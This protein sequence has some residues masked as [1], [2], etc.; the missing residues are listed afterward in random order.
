MTMRTISVLA[1]LAL[2]AS[3][4]LYSQVR[5]TDLKEMIGSS[6]MIFSGVVTE[7]EGGEDENGD[8]VTWTT[9]RVESPIRGVL[10]GSVRIKQ[11]G[12]VSEKGTMTLAHMRYFVEGER[13]LVMLYPPSELGFTSPIGMGQ[14]VWTVNEEGKV[15]GISSD[16]LSGLGSLAK[17]YNAVPD[18]QG[19]VLLSNLIALIQGLTNGGKQ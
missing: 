15:Q 18:S 17:Q 13:V 14:G 16:L 9:F 4:L 12:G 19:R 1:S 2:L 6:G 11:Y 10:P 8:I 5:Q 3:P 7:V